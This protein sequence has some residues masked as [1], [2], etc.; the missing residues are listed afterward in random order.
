VLEHIENLFFADNADPRALQ[1][2]AVERS[3]GMG[4]KDLQVLSIAVAL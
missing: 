3:L 2:I 4:S 1:P